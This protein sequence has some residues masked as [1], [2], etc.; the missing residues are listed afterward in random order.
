LSFS[1]DAVPDV[2]GYIA[3]YSYDNVIWHS[4][5]EG[6]EPSF[7]YQPSA[8]LRYYRICTYNEIGEGEWSDVISFEVV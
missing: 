1:C 4:L 5:Y 8:G 7:K 2:T 3:E 6:E